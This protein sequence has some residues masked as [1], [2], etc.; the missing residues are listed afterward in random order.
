MQYFTIWRRRQQRERDQE[1]EDRVQIR[2]Q[3]IHTETQIRNRIVKPF[4]KV[5]NEAS[6]Q[7]Q[8]SV[9]PAPST[10]PTLS[11]AA[12]TQPMG[13]TATETSN[14]FANE[15]FVGIKM[16]CSGICDCPYPSTSTGGYTTTKA[17]T[18]PSFSAYKRSVRAPSCNPGNDDSG[19]LNDTG[20]LVSDA[21]SSGESLHSC[22]Q[23]TISL[24]DSEIREDWN[25]RKF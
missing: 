19:F 25:D 2:L 9:G 1:V 21:S 7:K 20:A 17:T 15:N 4:D 5:G 14:G 6:V 24:T 23:S 16:C 8:E 18:N 11:T 12:T 10:Q 13:A 22:R 3:R